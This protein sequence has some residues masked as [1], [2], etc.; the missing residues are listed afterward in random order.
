MTGYAPCGGYHPQERKLAR[1][2]TFSA[3]REQ[4]NSNYSNFL[5]DLGFP[6]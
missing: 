5:L 6:L 2:I 3:E 1:T 4:E